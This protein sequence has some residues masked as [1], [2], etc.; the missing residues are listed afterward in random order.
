ALEENPIQEL[1]TKC[2]ASK[3]FRKLLNLAM[4]DL[5]FTGHDLLGRCFRRGL[6]YTLATGWESDEKQPKEGEMKVEVC[7]GLTPTTGWEGEEESEDED[8]DDDEDEDDND[9]DDD[10]EMEDF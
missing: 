2:F 7:L 4:P 8:Y 9:D 10:E 3:P 5:K 1:L 6:D